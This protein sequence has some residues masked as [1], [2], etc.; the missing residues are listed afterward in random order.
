MA[1][2]LLTQ[3]TVSRVIGAARLMRFIR[4]G[5]LTPAQ[6]TPSRV[7]YRVYDVRACLRRLE[8]GE[9]CPADRIESAR[10]NRSAIRHG[11]G[12]VPKGRKVRPAIE[13]IELDFST[14]T[15]SDL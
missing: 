9:I 3:H 14:V 6:R 1:A 13:E 4:A 10:T 12:Y 8:N 5:W 15:I 7:L 2:A 11:R